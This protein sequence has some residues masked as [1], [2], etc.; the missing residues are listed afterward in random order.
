MLALLKGL[1][2]GFI[3]E[4]YV[5]TLQIRKSGADS[6]APSLALLGSP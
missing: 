2:V 3:K 5:F 4:D 1:Q 6:I